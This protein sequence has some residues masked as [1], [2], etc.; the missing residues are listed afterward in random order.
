MFQNIIESTYSTVF[1]AL[2]R[3]NALICDFI[4]FFLLSG[5]LVFSPSIYIFLFVY[6]IFLSYWP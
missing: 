2:L 1:R 5:L 6:F 3:F 4:D